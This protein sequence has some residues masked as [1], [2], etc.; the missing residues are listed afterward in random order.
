MTA[1]SGADSTHQFDF[2]SAGV[3]PAASSHRWECS[4]C[5]DQNS[6]P[7]ISHSWED[8]ERGATSKCQVEGNESDGKAQH[9][10]HSGTDSG[11]RS[12]HFTFMGRP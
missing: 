6:V 12:K 3:A 11:V 1:V 8:H 2:L 5:E 9:T 7:S 10:N 4:K